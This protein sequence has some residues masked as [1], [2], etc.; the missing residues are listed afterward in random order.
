[1]L[2][3]TAAQAC[4]D[5]AAYPAL[6][7]T[8]AFKEYFQREG[9]IVVRGALPLAVCAEAVDGFLKEVHLATRA[10]FLRHASARYEPHV[11]TEAGHMRYPIMNLQDISGRRYPQFKAAGLALL[12]DP[13]LQ[14]AVATLLGEPAR[15]AHTMYFDGNQATWAHRDGHTIDATCPGAMIGAWI[16]AEDIDPGAG[17][18]FVLPG[19]HLRPVPGELDHDP[20]GA[21]YKAAMAEFV[22]RGPLPQVAPAL[23]QGDLLLWSSMTIHGSLPTTAPARS[24]RSFTGHYI[25]RSATLKRH[26]SRR[27]SGASTM[28]G[29][30]EILHH[31]DHRSLAGRAGNLLRSEYPG[32]WTLLRR[33]TSLRPWP[34][35]GRP[36]A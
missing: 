13:V 22:E 23:K 12:T 5:D 30:M 29:G 9:Y 8:A 3:D 35:A 33:L 34:L 16:A 15:L 14:R 36:S 24:R 26:L 19:S 32:A 4:A 31:S 28:L 11:Y 7:D 10:L 6:T 17:R 18:F 1:M 27:G 2:T 20:N 25:A 21:S